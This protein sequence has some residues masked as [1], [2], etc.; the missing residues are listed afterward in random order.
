MPEGKRLKSS[1]TIDKPLTIL[2]AVLHASLG[3]CL[4]LF[5]PLSL[6]LGTN[7]YL[8]GFFGFM[9]LIYQR[10]GIGFA[11]LAVAA[12]GA[13][14]RGDLGFMAAA[15]VEAA[16]AA[17][18]YRTG[19]RNMALADSLFWTVPGLSIV[20]A[21]RLIE[22][23]SFPEAILSGATVAAFAIFAS[24]IASL[25]ADYARRLPTNVL[26]I[27]RLG[28]RTDVPF[29]RIVFETSCALAMAPFMMFM[30]MTSNSRTLGLEMEI[31]KRLDSLTE[32]YSRVVPLWVSVKK[33]PLESILRSVE[34][35][36]GPAALGG[37]LATMRSTGSDV[38]SIGVLGPDGRIAAVDADAALRPRDRKGY[39]LSPLFA[40]ARALEP[41][42]FSLIAAKDSG[43]RPLVCF[44]L[45]FRGGTV[46]GAAFSFFKPDSISAVLEGIAGP[47]QCRG[48]LIA[49]GGEVVAAS[50]PGDPEGFRTA[51]SVE[52][53]S[54]PRVGGTWREIA[55]SSYAQFVDGGVGAGWTAA[56][57]QGIGPLRGSVVAFALSLASFALLATILIVLAS[58]YTSRIV[59]ASLEKLGKATRG[60]KELFLDRETEPLAESSGAPIDWP[61]E[62][63][64]E[65]VVLSRAF[66][67]AGELLDRRYR[68]TLT[69]L[70]EAERASRARR[71]LLSAV[72]HDIRGPMVGI[73]GIAE[74]L[75]ADLGDGPSAADARLIREA[76]AHLGSFVEEL[77][78][79]SSLEDGRLALR[80]EPFDLRALFDSAVSVFHAAARK[81]GLA[82]EFS[83]DDRLPT[84]V[85][86]D[87]ARLFQVIA[88]LIGNAVK[89]TSSGS[90]KVSASLAAESEGRTAVLFEIADTGIGISPEDAE[91]IFD[92]YYRAGAGPAGA[93]KGSGI[94]LPLAR[95]L[96]R[97]MGSDIA[98]ESSPGR[99]SVF[100]FS[101]SLAVKKVSAC[102]EADAPSAGTAPRISAR[103]LVVDDIDISRKHSRR[104]LELA[105][106]AVEEAADGTDA[107]EAALRSEF[108]LILMDMDLPSL[109]GRAA[110]RAILSRLAER[111]AGRRPL[112]I[113]LTAYAAE[114]DGES[115]VASGFDGYIVKN[116]EPGPLLAAARRASGLDAERGGGERP[117]FAED[118]VMDL[119]GLLESYMGNRGFLRAL[120][121]AFVA[122]GSKRVGDLSRSRATGDSEGLSQTLHSLVNIA[123]SGR[124]EVALRL[125]RAWESSLR[126]GR[127]VDGTA[128]D[129]ALQAFEAAV[130]AASAFLAESDIAEGRSGR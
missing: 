115:A 30:V 6:F 103:V 81:K 92:P 107:V 106:C 90:V 28:R 34:A 74:K 94:G 88:N 18:Y 20:A 22:G 86:G 83:F 8:G 89:Y 52:R 14:L 70:G 69:A 82:L 35:G 61:E 37:M 53:G 31:G 123:G 126:D 63:V 100:R 9:A 33:T 112:V 66:Q 58:A 127:T 98:V 25:L 60:F 78:D 93:E 80:S 50:D 55:G 125:L 85:I 101:V 3:F 47:T 129:A 67:E 2:M 87:R 95:G 65:V 97:L 42:K 104:I 120:L 119:D 57:V 15:L 24:T 102:E 111:G 79:R 40:D 113:A 59:V 41:A 23:Y 75:E 27:S 13:G 72:S 114:D 108:D 4:N 49:P 109:D 16:A 12:C 39:D 11:A 46:E 1:A 48:W 7:A 38:V 26:F 36:M 130:E 118:K 45:P 117:D 17:A 84:C 77:L 32:S 122:D 76:G 5:F 128:Q 91:R 105:G 124:A 54:T 51:I 44:V 121:E 21:A 68:E 62:G 110:A 29:R 96:V 56:F 73:V 19:R 99:G 71:D 10:A 43:G 64:Q 116:G